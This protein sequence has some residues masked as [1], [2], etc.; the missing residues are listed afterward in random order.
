MSYKE[1]LRDSIDIFFH[2]TTEGIM[3]RCYGG[4]WYTREFIP[5]IQDYCIN[6]ADKELAKKYERHLKN[7]K[8]F[9]NADF[10]FCYAVLVHDNK[11]SR[12][13]DEVTLRD[14]LTKFPY[15]RNECSHRSGDD[16]PHD[17][18]IAGMNKLNSTI[19]RFPRDF[20]SARLCSMIGVPYAQNNYSSTSQDYSNNT[21]RTDTTSNRASNINMRTEQ[22]MQQ[23]PNDGSYV[24]RFRIGL[25]IWLLVSLAVFAQSAFYLHEAFD[26]A[27]NHKTWEVPA[28]YFI[29]YFALSWPCFY[30]G[31]KNSKEQKNKF[32]ARFEQ[33]ISNVYVGFINALSLSVINS[34]YFF[35]VVLVAS[36]IGIGISWFTIFFGLGDYIHN[37]CRDTVPIIL[38]YLFVGVVGIGG[39]GSLYE[40]IYGIVLNL[41]YWK[42]MRKNANTTTNKKT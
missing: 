4:N 31:H 36:I 17:M 21:T 35:F 15:Y 20:Y 11:Y 37:F 5:H 14:Y 30:I 32:F 33:E 39:K 28:W 2:E 25:F 29:G 40:L 12:L 26:N 8:D 23:L 24:K 1:Q 6:G 34:M 22:K 38:S 27:A 19:V 7:K 41:R 13:I 18:Y 3:K 16:I 42:P 10:T 9:S